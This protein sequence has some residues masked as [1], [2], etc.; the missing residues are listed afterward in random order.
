MPVILTTDEERRAPGTRAK[1]LRLPLLD[2]ALTI[3]MRG[4]GKENEIA[5]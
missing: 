4:M 1:A 3:V 5:A 2:E